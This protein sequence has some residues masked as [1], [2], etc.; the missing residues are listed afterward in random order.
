MHL[1]PCLSLFLLLLATPL[2][3]ALIADGAPSASLAE[4]LERFYQAEY[5]IAKA[6]RLLRRAATYAPSKEASHKKRVFA[7]RLKKWERVARDIQEDLECLFEQGDIR[8]AAPTSSF[9]QQPDR[10]NPT[11]TAL[12]QARPRAKAV[13]PVPAPVFEVKSLSSASKAIRSKRGIAYNQ[14]KL[15][16]KLNIQ[17]AYNWDQR[18]NGGLNPGVDYVPMLWGPSHASTWF[19]NANA[20]LARGSTY[21]LAFNEPD[22]ETQA[23]MDVGE[24]VR[25]WKEYMSPF[26]G[27]AKL[28]SM[29]VT[30]GP[31]PKGISYIKRFFEAC[32]ECERECHMAVIHWY[33]S[34]QN[35]AYFKRYLQDTHDLLHKPIWL[36]EFQGSGTVEQQQAFL[37]EVIPWMEAQDYIERYAGFGDF[38][39]TY[40]ADES[41]TLTPLGE[42]YSSA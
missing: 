3:S 1:L 39:G 2:V 10:S 7:Q 42:T 12:S 36:T 5:Q 15:T 4:L 27:R 37:R 34:A 26:A 18:P 25:A 28:G 9:E 17:W 30:N 29:A 33:D 13:V 22:L 20:A 21:L 38:V 16:T 6:K 32:P 40:V 24:S 14:A 8:S 11:G 41:G 31:D 19:E 23:N 35:V